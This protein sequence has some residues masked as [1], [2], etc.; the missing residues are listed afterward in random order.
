M[1]DIRKL[2]PSPE[3]LAPRSFESRADFSRWEDDL[4]AFFEPVYS[5]FTEYPDYFRTRTLEFRALRQ[6]LPECFG[7][8]CRHRRGLE[9]GSGYG[10]TA[11]LLSP[12]VHELTGV[13]IPEKY[14]G[15]VSGDFENS[16]ELAKLVAN[17]VLK[18]K[19]VEF[20]AAWPASL[21]FEDSSFD[22]LFSQY[23]LEHI[24]DLPAA[25]SEMARVLRPG[26]LMIHVVPSTVD[27]F[28]AYTRAQLAAGY[29]S[30]IKERLKHLIRR[31]GEMSATGAIS[32]PL[33]SE[34][35]TSFE[36]QLQIYSL[37]S[38]LFPM[39]EQGF[40][41]KQVTLTRE[42]NRVIVLKRDS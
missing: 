5:L 39:L 30:L 11:A 10:F 17:D 3:L 24:P 40:S 33:H 36:H 6:L 18:L 13:D 9:L 1:D 19:N 12:H 23:L 8:A 28:F 20:K 42:V 7:P 34:F 15:Y 21:P 38:Y 25:I 37:E 41:V 16:T 35:A 22:F 2:R 27:M 29:R 32:P 26:G 4:R 14:S 31:R